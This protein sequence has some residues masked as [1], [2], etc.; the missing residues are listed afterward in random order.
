VEITI[1][2]LIF[3]LMLATAIVYL[4]VASFGE[5]FEPGSHEA[6]GAESGQENLEG[7]PQ[8]ES[9]ES[10]HAMTNTTAGKHASDNEPVGVTAAGVQGTNN[11]STKRSLELPLFLAAGVA[12]AV[13]GF[14]I[15]NNKNNSRIPYIVATAGSL[16]LIGLYSA[17]HVIGVPLI[18]LEHVGVL[19]LLVGGLQVGIIGCSAYIILSLPR[20]RT[21]RS[22]EKSI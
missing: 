11:E 1:I 3:A 5:N 14:W 2:Y 7:I 12:Y 18:G 17:S 9:A 19:D 21:A 20:R 6:K 10:N 16:I 15:I 22:A 8:H 13:V 4:V